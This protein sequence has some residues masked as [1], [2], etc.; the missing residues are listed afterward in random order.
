MGSSR[1][2][3]ARRTGR[4]WSPNNPTSHVKCASSHV[5]DQLCLD[6]HWWNTKQLLVE[7]MVISVHVTLMQHKNK[8]QSKMWHSQFNPDHVAKIFNVGIGTFSLHIGKCNLTPRE[9]QKTQGTASFH[10]WGAIQS[11]PMGAHH[12]LPQSHQ[13]SSMLLFPH[14]TLKKTI[15]PASSTRIITSSNQFQHIYPTH[16]A[17]HHAINDHTTI[18]LLVQ[19]ETMKM[20]WYSGN[21]IGTHD[22]TQLANAQHASFMCLWQHFPTL[23]IPTKTTHMNACHLLGNT[24]PTT[25]LLTTSSFDLTTTHK[26]PDTA[27]HLLG[28]GL[29][30]IPTP[31]QQNITPDT[32]DSSSIS[33]FKQELNLQVYFAG[34]P[35]TDY[36]PNGLWIKLTNE[37]APLSSRSLPP[38]NKPTNSQE[39]LPPPMRPPP[40]DMRT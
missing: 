17:E 34:K 20:P 4:H 38:S 22:Q 32:L 37:S 27:H 26:L 5:W 31:K 25:F 28:L 3:H 23:P 11:S 19:Q 7:H 13:P 6:I 14:P 30:F 39:P 18:S 21:S 15:P 9:T 24:H 10:C 40:T 36:A 33:R 16:I 1:V 35:P 8:L 2:N 12:L 29:K